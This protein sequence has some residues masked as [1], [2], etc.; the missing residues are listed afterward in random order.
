MVRALVA[1]TL[2][3]MTTAPHPALADDEPRLEL[4]AHAGY[5]NAGSHPVATYSGS[6]T[7]FATLENGQI[8][9]YGGHFAGEIAGGWRLT[10]TW[11]LGGVLGLRFSSIDHSVD[12]LTDRDLS[13][14]A[15]TLGGYVRWSPELETPWLL[16]WLSLG[17]GLALDSQFFTFGSEGSTGPTVARNIGLAIP[18]QV[19]LGFRVARALSTGPFASYSPVIG[20]AGSSA[21]AGAGDIDAKTYGVWGLGLEARVLAF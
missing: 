14:S 4:I 9:P 20:L 3:I 11:S 6:I 7:P 17:L 12:L 1:L 13:R 5:A 21:G 2:A 19:G 15:W 18:V 16:P 8:A 10:K